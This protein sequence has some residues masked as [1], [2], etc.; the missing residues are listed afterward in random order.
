MMNK[1]VSQTTQWVFDLDTA[2]LELAIQAYI[3]KAF[4]LPGSAE[5]KFDWA[6]QPPRCQ[7]VARYTQEQK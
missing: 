2:D 5:F 7:V 4:T 1:H 6:E 3:H